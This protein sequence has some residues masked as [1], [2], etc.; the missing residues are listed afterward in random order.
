[1]STRMY[2]TT[3]ITGDPRWWPSPRIGDVRHDAHDDERLVCQLFVRCPGTT[4]HPRGTC[5]CRVRPPHRWDRGLGSTSMEI[6]DVL[7]QKTDLAR[8]GERAFER[9]VR[10]H[11]EGRIEP[12][13]WVD[14]R[15]KARVRG[16]F[17][18]TVELWVERDGPAWS[19][20]CPAAEDGADAL[21][22]IPA[23]WIRARVKYPNWPLRQWSIL[24]AM[25]RRLWIRI[26]CFPSASCSLGIHGNA[27]TGD[28]GC[29]SCR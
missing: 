24:G 16:T 6:R 4:R 20:M 27:R 8:A 9:G 22:S 26:G 17:P 23:A 21:A 14:D 15:V 29:I 28:S 5:H 13:T 10:Y 19:C 11:A 3:N 12:E 25:L 18:Y 1:M 7:D 2:G